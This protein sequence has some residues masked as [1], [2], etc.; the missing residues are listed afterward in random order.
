MQLSR[1]GSQSTQFKSFIA[2]C[3]CWWLIFLTQRFLE[4]SP[5]SYIVTFLQHNNKARTCETFSYEFYESGI[6]SSILARTK[7]YINMKLHKVLRYDRLYLKT[8][9]QLFFHCLIKQ[10]CFAIKDDPLKRTKQNFFDFQ[11]LIKIQ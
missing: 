7:W 2:C 8:L 5:A 6:W 9:L 1:Q 3:C 4:A 11:N 10:K